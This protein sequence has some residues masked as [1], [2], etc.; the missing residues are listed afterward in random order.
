MRKLLSTAGRA[1][2]RAFIVTFV[3]LATGILAA[4]DLNQA[5]ALAGAAS[6]ASLDASFGALRQFVPQLK[7]TGWPEVFTTVVQTAV[8]GFI[9]LAIGTLASPNLG[10]ARAASLAG[11]LA[12]GTGLLRVVQAYLTPGESPSPSTGLNVG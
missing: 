10:E 5:Y 1:F 9:T 3:G 4:P 8:A 7:F 6:I 12:I 11:L 2:L